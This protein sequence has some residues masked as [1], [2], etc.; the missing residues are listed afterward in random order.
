MCRTLSLLRELD[1][2]KLAEM[3]MVDVA[4]HLLAEKREALLFYDLLK[5]VAELKGLSDEEVEALLAQFYTEINIDG[6]FVCIGDNRWGLKR[7]YPVE[8]AEETITIGRTRKKGDEY[9][10]Y[11]D[12]DMLLDEEYDEDAEEGEYLDEEEYLE[13][14]DDYLDD[15]GDDVFLEDEELDT[16]YNDD[17][18]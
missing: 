2:E 8:A 12:D 15:E 1:K 3:S 5:E 10:D 7:W 4:Y 14:E 17:E 16:D 18:Y 11:E 6:R 13:E 9:D